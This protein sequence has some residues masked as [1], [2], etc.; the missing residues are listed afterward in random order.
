MSGWLIQDLRNWHVA[1]RAR[2]LRGALMTCKSDRPTSAHQQN[3]YFIQSGMMRCFIELPT[4]KCNAV[5]VLPTTLWNEPTVTIVGLV[6]SSSALFYNLNAWMSRWLNVWM[7]EF[8]YYSLP[9]AHYSLLITHCFSWRERSSKEYGW[10]FKEITGALSWAPRNG[11][12]DRSGMEEFVFG[13]R[14][15][16][17]NNSI[18][19]TG[20]SG[21][22]IAS[23]N[24][25]TRSIRSRTYPR[26]IQR[27]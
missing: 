2:G 9:I 4:A 25:T 23:A 22:C 10:F 8:A 19:N 21:S 12:H 17:C 5:V 24:I 14:E 27:K 1:V 11:N 18:A 26:S 13:D 16:T 6:L 20:S 3:D 7:F 15:T